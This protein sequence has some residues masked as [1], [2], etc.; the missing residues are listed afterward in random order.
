MPLSPVLFEGLAEVVKDS[1]EKG[2]R[3]AIVSKFGNAVTG[4]FP[5]YGKVEIGVEG[6]LGHSARLQF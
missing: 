1:F 4:V 6:I 2:R 3:S 5:K